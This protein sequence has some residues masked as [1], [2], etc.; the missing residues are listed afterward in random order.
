MES[1]K[2][3]KI[4]FSSQPDKGDTRDFLS[5]DVYTYNLPKNNLNLRK[6]D[7]MIEY[8]TYKVQYISSWASAV[9]ELVKLNVERISIESSPFMKEVQNEDHLWASAA[10]LFGGN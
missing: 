10:W 3:K 8:C 1:E 6:S 5:I 7:W 9:E 4:D 2:E